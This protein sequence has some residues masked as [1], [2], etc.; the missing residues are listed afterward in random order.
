M[1]HLK[2][3]ELIQKSRADLLEELATL[4]KKLFELRGQIA[5][6]SS[7][8]KLSEIQT[9]RRDVARVKTVLMEQQR[10]ALKEKYNGKKLVPKD[11]R[12]KQVKSQRKV[13]PAKYANK[14]TKRAARRAKYLKP[15]KFALKA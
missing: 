10:K 4:E 1:G 9:V 8:Q 2:A 11:I 15:V 12:K 3:H 14:L 13:L 5:T 7:R 6:S